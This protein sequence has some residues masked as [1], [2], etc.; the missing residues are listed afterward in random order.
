MTYALITPP[1]AE[2]L[3]LA[4][5]KAHL[6]L[7]GSEEDAL[8][9]S[10]IMTSREFLEREAGMCLITQTWRLYLDQWPR[11]GVIR[12]VKS[13]V[14]VIQAIHVYDAGGVAGHVSLQDHLLDA[15]GR[16]ARLW[17]RDLP[18]P[19]QAVNG[20]EIEFTAGYGEAGA[21]VPDTLK[22]AMLLHVG[23]MFA[24]RG[25]LSPNQQPAGVPDGYDRLIAPFRLRRL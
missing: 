20:I 19:G 10:L 4:E 3:T 22:R 1:Q 25:V 11:D 16:P 17:L 6:R 13:P 12:I 18:P 14:Q 9:L 15:E 8:L 7:D 2:P 5:A 23:H 24:F 21:D